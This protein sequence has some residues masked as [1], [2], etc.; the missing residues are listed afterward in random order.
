MRVYDL[1]AD[2]RHDPSSKEVVIH[3]MHGLPGSGKST[4]ARSISAMR[5]NLDDYRRMMSIPRWDDAIE[6]V[7]QKAML[8]GVMSA[9][10]AGYDVV[11]D[12]THMGYKLPNRY[13]TTLS[14]RNVIFRVHDLTDMTVEECIAVD[15]GRRDGERVGESVIRGMWERHQST[16]KDG[17]KLT[18]E[19]MNEWRDLIR[20]VQPCV[21]DDDLPWCV[22]F[23]I[24]GT[25]AKHADRGPYDL[26]ELETD[27]LNEAV[28]NLIDIYP[29]I[30]DE[31]KIILL[32]GRQEEY[33]RQTEAW[34]RAHN[35]KYSDLHMRPTGDRRPD[36]VVK[37]QLF[38]QNIRGRYNV[39]AVYDD[40]NQ[41]VDL[42]RL[43]YKLPC[44]QVEYGDF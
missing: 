16:R 42:W 20:P 33:R 7:V 24:D 32:S 26:E 4:Y 39:E 29:Y 34:L 30:D 38:E 21:I 27:S 19:W 2:P 13:R 35:I 10:D 12:N 17:W 41:V 25:L 1:A 23:D 11:I 31:I 6:K 15:A 44:H 18:D 28:A 14:T 5:F 40:R 37:S 22:L 36:F 3:V 9:V 8:R 43:V